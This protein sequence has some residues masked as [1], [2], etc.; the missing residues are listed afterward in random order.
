[1]HC[2]MNVSLYEVDFMTSGKELFEML[3]DS[4]VQTLDRELDSLTEPLTVDQLVDIFEYDPE[5]IVGILDYE[6]FEEFLNER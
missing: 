2:V 3:T 4:E 6:S 5:S 1:M